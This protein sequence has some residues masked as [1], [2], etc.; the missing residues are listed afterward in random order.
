MVLL[1]KTLTPMMLFD[2]P[3]SLFNLNLFCS[4]RFLVFSLPFRKDPSVA[5]MAYFCHF[6]IF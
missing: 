6:L 4:I 2:R 1:M 3:L 5:I